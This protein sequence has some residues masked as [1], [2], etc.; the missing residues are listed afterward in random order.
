MMLEENGRRVNM[1]YNF[2]LDV[3]MWSLNMDLQPAAS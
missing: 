3:E 1:V 2:E